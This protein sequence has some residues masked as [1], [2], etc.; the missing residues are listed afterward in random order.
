MKQCVILVGGRGS[1]L[2]LET[3]TT[4]KPLLDVAGRPFLEYLI[5]RV[6]NHGFDELLLIAGHHGQAFSKLDGTRRRGLRIRVHI[7]RRPMGTA[8]AL[9]DARES[10]APKF[11][12]MN[13]DSILDGNWLALLP[14]LEAGATISMALTHVPNQGRYGGVEISD[15]RV[16]GFREKDPLR[17]GPGPINAGVYGICR[18]PVLSLVS[19][20]A[21]LEQDI[22]PVFCSAGAVTGIHIAG[23]FIDIGIPESLAEARAT[24][25]YRLH[26]PAAIFDRDDTFNVDVGHTHRVEDLQWVEGAREVVRRF[27]DAGFWVFV[28]TNQSGIARGKYDVATMDRFHAAMQADLRRIGAHVDQ[29]YHCPHHPDGV[30]QELSIVCGCRK[31]QPGMLQQ[32]LAD[33]PIQR[34]RSFF[35]GD[36]PTDVAAAE[37]IGLAGLR[38]PG[39][40]L[41]TFLEASG[42]LP[43][44]SNQDL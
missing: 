6:A 35:V 32:I 13:G 43:G 16:V 17:T 36:Q 22:L 14:A 40:S 33:W 24:L 34:E 39:G 29:F 42:W 19:G 31:P 28:A 9:Y 37:A 23:Y 11:L 12:L 18:D 8:G 20:P 27:N 10:L 5:D 15:D 1:R 26:R 30:I 2:G 38:F 41:F 21:S 4:P 44:P 3:S 25:P 7:E